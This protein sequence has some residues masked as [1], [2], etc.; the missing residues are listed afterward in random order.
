MKTGLEN[1]KICVVTV[2]YKSEKH[3]NRFL[4]SLTDNI[5]MIGKL[6]IVDNNS[7]D[8]ATSVVQSWAAKNSIELKIITN[9]ENLGY[10]TAANMGIRVAKENFAYILL[11]NNDLTLEKN[12][13]RTLLS[14]AI[15]SDGDVIGI[16]GNSN[17]GEVFLGFN[18][19]E[20]YFK[21]I[22]FTQIKKSYLQFLIDK[23]IRY[24]PCDFPSGM[25][26]LFRNTFFE[27][28]GYFD[29]ELFFSGDET[30]FA[31]RINKNQNVKSFV[32]LNSF[33]LVDHVSFGTSGNSLIKN[34]NYIRGCIYILLKHTDK[35]LSLR[36]W[37]RVAHF[38]VTI[39][40]A[41]PIYLPYLIY[42]VLIFT[43]KYR[44]I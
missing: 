38:G 16:P 8:S 12:T 41:R 31:I 21:L 10:T 20:S 9:T 3:I 26:L 33:K 22:K 37:A 14:N 11:T 24:F 19:R 30:D 39:I 17:D 5:E 15:D 13:L 7:R 34:K 32:S 40:V 4:S 1:N 44:N 42:Y 2:L 43:L 25:L 35:V 18:Y 6:V 27:K 23:D 28:I 36:Y 29:E